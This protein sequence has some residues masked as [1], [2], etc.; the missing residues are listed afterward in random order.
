M[1]DGPGLNSGGG[2]AAPRGLPAGARIAGYRIAGSLGAGGM[3]TVY[4]AVDERLNRKVALKVLSAQLA[5]D[6]AFR[7]R[8]IRESRSAKRSGSRGTNQA[9][10][11]S[12]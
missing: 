8:F 11:P 3:A 4:L 2:K 5:G 9:R 6:E 10:T 12:L 1:T 7:L